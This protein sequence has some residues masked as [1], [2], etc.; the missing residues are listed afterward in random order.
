MYS[1]LS[2]NS[3][4]RAIKNTVQLADGG[5]VKQTQICARSSRIRPDRYLA[6]AEIPIDGAALHR[7]APR[8][9]HRAGDSFPVSE[10]A[11]VG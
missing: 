4:C 6:S 11:R 5:T 9:T 1:K 2:R 3:I 7:I 10:I 8:S